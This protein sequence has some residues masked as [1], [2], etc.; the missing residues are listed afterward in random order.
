MEGNN[1]NFY[2][3]V[4]DSNSQVDV[5]GLECWGTAR[6]KFWKQEAIDNAHLYSQ[7]NLDRMLK[8]KAPKMKVKIFHHKTQTFKTKNV[9]MELHHTSLPQ[10]GAGDVA[11]QSWNLTKATPWGHA[12]MDPYRHTGYDLVK[13]I[14]GTNSW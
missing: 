7:R 4:F 9:S 8:G 2:G 3:Y 10:R 12:S 11:H 13:I 5:F 14:K 6:K 1:P